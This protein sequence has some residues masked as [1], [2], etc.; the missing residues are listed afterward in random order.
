[1]GKVSIV[2]ICLSPEEIKHDSSLNNVF[3]YESSLLQKE[4]CK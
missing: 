4:F 1:M 3:D 2:K